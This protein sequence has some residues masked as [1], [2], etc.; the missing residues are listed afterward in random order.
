MTRNSADALEEVFVAHRTQLHRIAWRI[1]GESETADEV[2][3]DAYLKLV[4]GT[5]A[6]SV[7]RPYCYCCQVVR[8]LALDHCRRRSLEFTYRVHTA[9][10]ELPQI[11][12]GTTPERR[13]QDLRT[14]QTIDVLLDCLPQRTRRAFEL[15]R[16][17]GLTQRE[18][19]L[20]LGCSATLVNFML[21]DAVGAISGCRELLDA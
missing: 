5:C 7:E 10:G 12:G 2:T 13:L 11:A 3:Q 18:I 1:V 17:D 20:Q 6:R 4:E 16:L 8:N 21:K 15:N 14:L 9:D 19:A